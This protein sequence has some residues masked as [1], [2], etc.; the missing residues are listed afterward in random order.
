MAQIYIKQKNKKIKLPVVQPT[1]KVTSEQENTS[2]NINAIGEH[3]LL[4]KR[5]LRT[6]S[7]SSFFPN[8][9]ELKNYNTTKT[10]MDYVEDIEKMKR[11]GVVTLHLANEFTIFA[12]IE[13]FEHQRNELNGDVDYTLNFK[14]YTSLKKTKEKK[15]KKTGN[16]KQETA[17]GSRVTPTDKKTSTY[18]VKKGQCLS[19][20]AQLVYGDASQWPKIYNANKS[21]I[22][23][24]PNR[25]YPKQKLV[26]P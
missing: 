11:K 2:V 26:I 20:I 14:E 19:S 8:K 12:T 13:S 22:G 21:T 15:N 16:K 1:W 4:G 23:S 10:P 7:Y 5:K 3:T 6:I 17:K 24:N 25:I 9:N 18:T